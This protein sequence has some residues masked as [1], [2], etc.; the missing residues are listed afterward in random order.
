MD[1]TLIWSRLAKRCGELGHEGCR[2]AFDA[3]YMGKDLPYWDS[4]DELFDHFLKR[5]GLTWEKLKEISPYEYMPLEEWKSYYVY[6]K[7]D[8]KTGKPT[9]FPT[10][11]KKCELYLESMITLG[12]TGLPFAACE[13]PPASKNYDPLPYYI[14]P[15]ESPLEKNGPVKKFPLIMTSGRIPMYHH[16]TLRNVPWIREMYPAP[17]LWIHPADAK[18]YAVSHKD[19]VWIESL[20]GKI[21]GIACVTTGIVPG[22]VFMER[23][24]NPE[25]LNTK[26]H[27]WQ[28]TN[29]NVLTKSDAPFNDVVG[30]YTLRGFLVKVYKAD[31]PPEGLWLKSKD[32][33]SWL[34]QSSEPTAQVRV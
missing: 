1:E 13:L 3:E 30:T 25:T 5:V 7:I 12:K 17:E 8:P 18:K 6:K 9:G 10:P 19:W 15:H 28:E 32:F 24:W 4:M 2:K 16:S 21:R 11:S 33:K 34:P 14:E 23:F 22:V 20:R 31:S 26:T 29:V 27:G